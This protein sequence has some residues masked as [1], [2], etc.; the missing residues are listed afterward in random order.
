[1]AVKLINVFHVPEDQVDEFLKRWTATSGVYARTAGFLESHLHRNAGVGHQN[2]NFINIATWASSEAF[3]DA[4]KNYVPGE[5][6]IPG[7]QFYPAL[8][9]EVIMTK[10]LLPNSSSG[11]E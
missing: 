11:E 9:E 10:N 4:H 5:E 3:I 7:I 6:S 2:F 8:Y 1:M